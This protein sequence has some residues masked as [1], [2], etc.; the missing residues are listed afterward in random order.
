MRRQPL[1]VERRK[2]CGEMT[3]IYVRSNFLRTKKKVDHIILE[4][5]PSLISL[6]APRR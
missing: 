5:D 6:S 3:K 4:R 2:R 1:K